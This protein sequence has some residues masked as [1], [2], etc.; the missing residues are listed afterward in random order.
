[1]ILVSLKDNR[2]LESYPARLIA[3]IYLIN[4]E[5]YSR[6]SIQLGLGALDYGT[7]PW[8]FFP[9]ESEKIRKQAAL[10][11]GTLE[12]LHYDRLVYDKLLQAMKSDQSKDVRNTSYTV[13]IK[14][15]RIRPLP[16]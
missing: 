7:F 11:L 10:L 15:A 5:P 13:L 4:R 3:A 16:C 1:M 14:L 2:G 9:S 12:P 6:K 8:E